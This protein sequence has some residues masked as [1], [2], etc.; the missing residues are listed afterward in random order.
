MGF[1]SIEVKMSTKARLPKAEK[2][3]GIANILD[4][5]YPDP[6]IPLKHSSPYTLLIAV[7]LSAQ[8]TDERVNSVTPQLFKLART[9]EKMV[10]CTVDEIQQY[11][12]KNGHL[13]LSFLKKELKSLQ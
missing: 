1:R 5:L 13:M 2:A 9:P 7:L 4:S 8:C 11:L 10:K 6:P 3:S 12:H